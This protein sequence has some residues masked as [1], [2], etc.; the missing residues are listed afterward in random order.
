MQKDNSGIKSYLWLLGFAGF[1]GCL[2]FVFHEPFMLVFL[3]FF[4][5]WWFA[6]YM[7]SEKDEI[8]I[9]NN[10]KARERGF[11]VCIIMV[12]TCILVLDRSVFNSLSMETKYN[13]LVSVIFLSFSVLFIVYGYLLDKYEKSS[14]NIN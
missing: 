2:Y 14:R 13:I 10:Y 4:S 7:D 8:F 12:L 6:K 1:L 11:V 5:F 9:V 3:G